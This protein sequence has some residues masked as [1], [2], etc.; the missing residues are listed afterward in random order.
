[1][2]T[3]ALVPPPSVNI[4][5]AAF[6]L[7]GVPPFSAFYLIAGSPPDHRLTYNAPTAVAGQSLTD[8]SAYTVA[9]GYLG[10][11]R[12]AFGVA[13]QSGAATVLIHVVDGSGNAAAGVPGT[14][15][16]IGGAGVKGPFVLDANLQPTA[17]ATATSASGWLVYFNVPSGTLTLGAGAGYSVSAADTPTVAD[18]VSLVQATVAKGTTP[19]APPQNVSFQQTVMPIFI[20]RGCYNCHSGN[21]A[22]RRLGDLVLDGAPMKIWTALVQTVSPTFNTTRVNL[23]APEKSLVLTMPSLETPPDAHPTVVFT[24][25]SDPDYQKILVWIKEGAKLN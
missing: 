1:M 24:S 22:G 20:N 4:R 12:T 14:A 19:P 9:D 23:T 10:K 13:A 21:G 6:T 8:V 2:A 16:V 17:M 5:G 11:L 25:S 15:V 3:A 18:A 7:D